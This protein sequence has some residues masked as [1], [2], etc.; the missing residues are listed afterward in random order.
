[1]FSSYFCSFVRT[2]FII[3]QYALQCISPCA[4]T[5]THKHTHTH[6]A[7]FYSCVKLLIT[8]NV[9]VQVGSVEEF[10]GQEK[11]AVILSTV[12]VIVKSMMIILLSFSLPSN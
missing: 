3:L 12:S 10:Q 8:V 11:L 1:M 4:H 6:L 9:F 7:F 5:H 2:L